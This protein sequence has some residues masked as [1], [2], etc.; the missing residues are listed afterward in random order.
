MSLSH[1][2]VNSTRFTICDH[3]NNEHWAVKRITC[4]ELGLVCNCISLIVFMMNGVCTFNANLFHMHQSIREKKVQ[5]RVSLYLHHEYPPL[6]LYIFPYTCYY[7]LYQETFFWC[8]QGSWGGGGGEI[9]EGDIVVQ[10]VFYYMV[11]W[12]CVFSMSI[13]FKL[14]LFVLR[15]C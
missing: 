3:T 14:L 11:T 4:A 12:E 10:R 5:A 13:R 7:L 1:R 8:V 9:E 6:N 2:A 15:Q